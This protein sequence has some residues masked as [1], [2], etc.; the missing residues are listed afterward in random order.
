MGEVDVGQTPGST[1]LHLGAIYVPILVDLP[2][3]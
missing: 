3:H 2:A 1:G